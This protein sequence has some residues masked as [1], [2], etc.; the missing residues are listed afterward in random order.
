MAKIGKEKLSVLIDQ[1]SHYDPDNM[2]MAAKRLSQMII[3]GQVN[4]EGDEKT[5]TIIRQA[6]MKQI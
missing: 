3:A 1:M 4:L 2:Q 6:Y 5:A